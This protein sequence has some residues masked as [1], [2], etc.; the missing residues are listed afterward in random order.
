ML[1][2]PNA[3]LTH[4]LRIRPKVAITNKSASVFRQVPS[5][6]VDAEWERLTDIGTHII[7]SADVCKLGKDL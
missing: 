7:N 2:S 1:S 4:R 6:D 3:L 5:P